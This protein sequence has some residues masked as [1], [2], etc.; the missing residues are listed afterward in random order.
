MRRTNWERTERNGF[1]KCSVRRGGRTEARWGHPATISYEAEGR[2]SGGEGLVVGG[3]EFFVGASAGDRHA[4]GAFSVEEERGAPAVGEFALA[5][6]RGVVGRDECEAKLILAGEGSGNF[7][8]ETDGVAAAGKIGAESFKHEGDE[9]EV[10][11]DRGSRRVEGVGEGAAFGGG[12]GK[13]RW[14]SLICRCAR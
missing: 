9:A 4:R 8:V 11:V 13:V 1:G 5:V 14:L 10:V 7:G 12:R 3:V 2:A 6:D